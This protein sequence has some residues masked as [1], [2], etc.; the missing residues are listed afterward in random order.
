MKTISIT[1]FAIAFAI[2]ICCSQ[3]IILLKSGE[4]IPAEI[5]EIGTTEIMYKEFNIQEAS[6]ISLLKSDIFMIRYKNGTKDIFTDE[7]SDNKVL[8]LDEELTMKGRQD[9]IL[10]YK[11]KNT[12]AGWTAVT[13][14]LLSPLIGAI[15]ATACASSTPSTQNLNMADGQLME[16]SNYDK[17][18]KDQA[19]KIKRKK[20]WSAFGIS[21]GI[22]LLIIL[23][24]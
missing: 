20:V 16:Y 5:L 4:E 11:G 15:P 19:R 14:I 22:W 8:Y 13:T 2:T 6:P 1:I 3:D 9:A 24:Q 12:G 18:Y 21:S 10:N 23:S 17:A 7:N